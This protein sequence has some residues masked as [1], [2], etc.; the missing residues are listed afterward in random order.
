MTSKV[1]VLAYSK[2][3]GGAE[4]SALKLH[5]AL[6]QLENTQ[7]VFGTLIRSSKDFY[8]VSDRS[9]NLNFLPLTNYFISKSIPFKYVWFPLIALFDLF[10][11]RLSVK[12][13]KID[14]VVSFGAGV[15]CVIFLALFGT[16]IRQITSERIDPN[17]KV[18]KPSILARLLRPFMYK[19]G[20]ICS[21]QT[22]GFRDWVIENWGVS[23]V[24]TPNHFD[25]P[26]D[27]YPEGAIEGPVI[28]VGRPAF[29]KGYDL[30]LNAW[31]LVEGADSREL[32]IV[33]DDSENFVADI[34]K[35]SGCRNVRIKSLTDNLP[36]L[37]NQ[38]SMFI[39]TARF[40]GYP[41][42]IA[43]AIIYGIP[44]MSTISSDIVLDWSEAQLCVAINDISPEAMSS[45]ILALLNDRETLV[46]I[47][48]NGVLNRDLFSWVS[49][50]QSWLSLLT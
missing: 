44:V 49:V 23:A 11:I 28:A 38:S 30:L 10:H 7:A 17:P 19:H 14:T 42:A 20:V 27:R 22:L 1:L 40:E 50:R 9:K 31:A 32:W 33:C 39:S 16:G 2:Q 12:R 26:S 8:K 29:Q 35:H 24:V 13:N 5:H 47:S 46:K 18:Y 37:F 25:I 4:K 36:G 34:I 43:E 41:N 21:V 48:N 3:A 45:Q 6:A 15:G